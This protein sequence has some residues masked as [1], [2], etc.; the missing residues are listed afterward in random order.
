VP[1]AERADTASLDL[2]YRALLAA[3]GLET[4]H[5]QNLRQRGLSDGAI[6]QCGYRTLP[7]QG[8]YRIVHRLVDQF[9]TD[10]IGK[11]PGFI[12]RE[13][14]RD[15]YW[16][17]SMKPGQTGLVV[18]VRNSDCA[19]TGLIVRC[20]DPGDGGKYRW[21]SSRHHD[22]PGPLVSVHVPSH[23]SDTKIIRLTE[24]VLKADVATALSGVL[25]IGLPGVGPWKLALPVL[26]HLKPDSVL[27]AWDSDWRS[28]SHVAR[29]LGDCAKCLRKQGFMVQVEDWDPHVA[30]GI[31]DLLAHG[32]LPVRKGWAAALAAM[33]RGTAR[34]CNRTA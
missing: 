32:H 3:L 9:G 23:T 33:Y 13:N 16:T 8:R 7:E 14:H 19:I 20:D 4:R 18:P 25:T 34:V 31:D 15:G 1:Q 29:S 27:L 22:G 10:L 30:K 11:I 6:A 2:V 24:G 5:R 28:N 21:L 26:E 17:L 12:W